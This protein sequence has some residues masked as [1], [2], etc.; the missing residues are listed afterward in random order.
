MPFQ[1]PLFITA[2][3]EPVDSKRKVALQNKSVP[4]QWNP[5]KANIFHFVNGSRSEP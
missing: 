3:R 4:E 5:I 1:T 2:M